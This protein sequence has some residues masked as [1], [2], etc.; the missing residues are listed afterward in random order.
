LY[1]F[2]IS[3]F[4][5][6]RNLLAL[7]FIILTI[8]ANSALAQNPAP[9][10]KPGAIIVEGGT[11]HLGNGKVIT[12]GMMMVEN[13]KIA[14]LGPKD[15]TSMPKGTQATIINA[16]GK[17]VYPGLIAMNTIVG[18]TEI[19][20]VRS[21]RDY[22]EV[23]SFN[24]SVR[25][26][27]AYNTDSELI[28]TIRSNGVLLTQV[29]PR[30]GRISGQSSVLALDGWNWEDA[31]VRTD[32]GM[33]LNWPNRFSWNRRE[34]KI[35]ENEDYPSEI[36]ALRKEFKEARAYGFR[37]EGASTNLKLEA[38]QAIFSGD[39]TLFIHEN[40]ALS[41]QQAV[42]FCKEFNIKP[43]FIGARE[44]WKIVEFLK[45]NGISVVLEGTQELPARD[46]ENIDQPFSTPAILQE[47]GILYAISEE[48][49]W[50]QRNLAF[51]AG[52]ST[53]YGLSMEDALS[54]VTLHPA[55]ILGID[56][57]YGSLEEGK[58]GTFFISEG[59]ALDMRGN[60]ISKAFIDGREVDL[61]NKQKELYQKYKAK[62]EGQ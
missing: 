42:L 2:G 47:A 22:R 16:D 39:Q 61:H 44:S 8:Q 26:L 31:V 38:M 20:L 21:T 52:Q 30:G 6:M 60:K 27:I 33:H 54:A 7:V 28:P 10:A 41:M 17:H 25:S 32:D 1:Y 37:P 43:T 12:N 56:A 62:Y 29:V 5:I 36:E 40:D 19:D 34:R 45:E 49:S 23:G 55:K 35:K 51:H 15:E 24:P 58:S 11:F 9:G 59:N 14:L 18:L 50:Q 48:G 57:D 4:Q 53:A 13:G 3:K 46:Y